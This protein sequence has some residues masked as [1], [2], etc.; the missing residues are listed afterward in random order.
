ME[1]IEV[2]YKAKIAGECDM[3]N[4]GICDDGK[5]TCAEL[6]N[7]IYEYGKKQGIKIEV[8]IWYSGEKLCEFLKIDNTLDLLFLDIEL[9]STDGIKVGNFI[10]EELENLETAIIYISSNSSY[11]MQLFE[12]QPSGFLIKPLNVDKIE[13][14]LSKSIWLYEKKNQK[15][16][17]YSKGNFYKIP[18]KE[19]VYFCSEN[20]K[21]NIITKEGTIQFNGKLKE[22]QLMVPH[23]FIMIHQ[24]YMINLNYMLEG[25]YEIVK[26]WG[27]T[28]LNI[29]QPYRK[30]VRAQIMQ[31][32]WEKK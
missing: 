27:G 11:A 16:E 19:I 21:I 22:I 10:R 6:E 12:V 13:K 5:E 20:K 9:I 29:S 4:I 17:Y 1:N 24:S 31:Y 28:L 14:I 15:F 30:S 8:S 25:S 26:M 32:K 7:M 3:L 2:E 23:N 18:Y